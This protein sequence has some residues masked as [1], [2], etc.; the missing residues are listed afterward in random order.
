MH[1]R[2]PAFFS[3]AI[4]A[5]LVSCTNVPSPTAPVGTGAGSG[6]VATAVSDG[7]ERALQNGMTA[8]EVKHIMGEPAEI[9]PMESPTGKAE[10]WVYHRTVFGNVEQ[11]QVGSQVIKDSTSGSDGMV[12]TGTLAEVPIYKQAVHKDLE[13]ISLL[14]FD[15]KFISQKWTVER[16]LDYQ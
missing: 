14:M 4:A 10:V 12:H 16:R 11:V 7:P 15:G 2:Y 9:K 5:L 13:T 1:L 6:P 3:I 8:D